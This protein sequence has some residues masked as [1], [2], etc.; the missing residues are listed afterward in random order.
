MADGRRLARRVLFRDLDTIQRWLQ[1]AEQGRFEILTQNG[2][3][4]GAPT[5]LPVG[6]LAVCQPITGHLPRPA[7]PTAL[8]ESARSRWEGRASVSMMF[9]DGYAQ[10]ADAICCTG[11]L[12]NAVLCA[13]HA[14][15]AQRREWVINEKRLAQRAGLA[16]LQIRMA[17][18]GGSPEELIETVAAV[19]TALEIEP[20]ATRDRSASDA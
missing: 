15:L 20:L 9:A 1:E 4:V 13:S 6:E 12:A 18:P 8:A 10:L 11:M 16:E 3:I 19:S 14:R 7:F 17:R 2:Y 5:Y